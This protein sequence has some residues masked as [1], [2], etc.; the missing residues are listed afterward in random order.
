MLVEFEKDVHVLVS[1]IGRI[2]FQAFPN[3]VADNERRLTQVFLLV[4]VHHG[5]HEATQVNFL[6]LKGKREKISHF[7]PAVWVLVVVV[8][9]VYL[10]AGTGHAL[11]RVGAA[12]RG[13]GIG[14]VRTPHA[15]LI[16]CLAIVVVVVVIHLIVFVLDGIVSR[17]D[18]TA[19]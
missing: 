17:R 9:V 7:E 6:N 3:S 2:L 12:I 1:S 13:A 19:R 8:V 14:A 5:F 18:A 11:H 4:R 16:V 10:A 15:G